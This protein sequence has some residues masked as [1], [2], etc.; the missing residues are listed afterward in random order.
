M[1]TWGFESLR[2]LHNWQD[3][4][5][6]PSSRTR[7][8]KVAQAK[9]CRTRGTC[10]LANPLAGVAQ[11]VEHLI[12]NQEVEGSNPSASTIVWRNR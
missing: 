12:R 5:R 1:D 9:R 10:H 3:E 2:V 11:L 7:N 4:V 6:T 8:G